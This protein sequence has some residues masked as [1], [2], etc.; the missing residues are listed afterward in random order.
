M[1]IDRIKWDSYNPRLLA[2][3]FP[4]EE[5]STWSQLIVNDTQEAWLVSGGVY[6]GPFKGGRHTLETENIPILRD[7][8]GIPFGGKSPFSAEVWYISKTSVLDLRWGT[9]EPIPLRDPEFGIWVPVRAFGQY[10][11][12][13]VNGQKFLKKLVGTLPRFDADTVSE[14]FRGVFSSKIKTMLSEMIVKDRIPVLELSVHLDDISKKLEA[15]FDEVVGEYGLDVVRFSLMSINAPDNDPSVI[16]LKDALA[17]KAE[18]GILGDHYQQVKSFDVLEAAAKNEGTAGAFV[19]VGLGTGLGGAMN[20]GIAS[21]GAQVSTASPGAA[22]A[23][24]GKPAMSMM[25][26][27][28]LIEKLGKMKEQGLLTEEE[29]AEQKRRL[30]S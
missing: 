10:G 9:Q 20:G 19:G 28:E 1:I 14:Y 26:K 27:L 12:R 23:G 25:E 22:P 21:V 6:E 24:S 3:K 30:L 11:I 16:K 7:F 5:L 29:F 13:V 15:V 8:L 2:W 17:R 4:S 18:V